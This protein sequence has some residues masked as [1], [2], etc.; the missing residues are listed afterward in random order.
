[1]KSDFIRSIE[2]KSKGSAPYSIATI[3][4]VH[5]SASA[6]TGSKALFDEKGRNLIGWVGGGCAERFISEQSLEAIREKKSRIVT[7]DLDDEIFGLGIACGGKM[8]VFIE[9]IFPV[10]QIQMP[11]L[12]EL[13]GEADFLAQSFGWNIQWQKPNTFEIQ[14]SGDVFYQLALAIAQSRGRSAQSLRNLKDLPIQFATA[15]LSGMDELFIVGRS[16]ITEALA[17]FA[18]QLH[19]SVRVFGPAIAA[20]DYPQKVICECLN[21]NY[22]ELSFKRGSAVIIASHHAGDADFIQSAIDAGAPY[23]GMIGSRKRA[24]EIFEKLGWLGQAEFDFPV[25]L[26]AGLDI[27]ARTPEEIAFSVICEIHKIR[28]ENGN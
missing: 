7:A 12:E 17:R 18:T 3:I 16:R 25:Y 19:W 10:E 5:G 20:K 28:M 13:N 24:L 2:E 21:E 11:S 1:M 6:R 26:P 9:P 23:V 4:Q 22:D 14:N 8:D 27:D 15:D